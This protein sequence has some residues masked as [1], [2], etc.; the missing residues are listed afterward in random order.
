MLTALCLDQFQVWYTVIEGTYDTLRHNHLRLDIVYS[1]RQVMRLHVTPA[2][3]R[4]VAFWK[5][6]R[7]TF[8][9]VNVVTAWHEYL[10]AAI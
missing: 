1:A 6:A 7:C 10:A 3:G 8:C 9:H 2:A 4:G 5:L